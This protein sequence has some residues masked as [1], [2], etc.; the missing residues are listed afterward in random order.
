[1]QEN[2][3]VTEALT[4]ADENFQ[5]TELDD[6]TIEI[7]KYVGTG[8]TEVEIPSTID[9]KVNFNDLVKINK[10]RLNKIPEL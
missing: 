8:I 7:S 9:G 2:Q 1:M 10:F 5:Y 6:G 3:E 4:T